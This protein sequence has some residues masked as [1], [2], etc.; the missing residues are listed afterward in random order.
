[1]LHCIT[2]F[3][4]NVHLAAFWGVLLCSNVLLLGRSADVCLRIGCC[5]RHGVPLGRGGR[6]FANVR[7]QGISQG[8]TGQQEATKV[9]IV[10]QLLNG[11]L[12]ED[13]W[14]ESGTSRSEGA[15]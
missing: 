13:L 6:R 7:V 2:D 1:M 8:G 5:T 4:A 11:I 3:C 14:V 9:G 15:V 12:G 10:V